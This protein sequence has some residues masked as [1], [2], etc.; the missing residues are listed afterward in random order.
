MKK[1]FCLIFI[2]L[3]SNCSGSKYF[4]K[5]FAS[6]DEW[7]GDGA[8]GFSEYKSIIG[9]K[10]MISTSE[11]FASE[12]GVEILK[13]GGNAIDSAITAQMVLNVVEPHS[14]G[15]GGG[16]FLLYHHK[17]SKRNIYF[18]GRE[19]APINSFPEMFLDN[20]GNPQKFLDVVGSGLAVA[21]PGALHALK[22]AHQKY[23]KIKWQKLFEPAIK[24][25]REGYPLTE[26]MFVNL[27]SIKHL[28]SADGM[29]IYFDHN[30]DPKKLA[31][32]FVIINSLIPLKP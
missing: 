30:G 31:L 16:L 6:N 10:Y 2:L 9:E 25:A 7:S 17:K 3:T 15:I 28:S 8:V 22:N 24:I 4:Y 11:K 32:L 23:G 14:S 1:I 12:A 18:N 29:K 26:K 13:I 21:T 19:T 20:E 5:N 27:K